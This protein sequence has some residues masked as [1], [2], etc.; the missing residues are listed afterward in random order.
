MNTCECDHDGSNLRSL[1][2]LHATHVR[3]ETAA[4]AAACAQLDA[5]VAAVRAMH[6]ADAAYGCGFY[7][8]DD[9]LAA[10]ELTARLAGGISVR[11][12]D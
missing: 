6:A 3:R 7:C 5:L 11:N 9:W 8:Q 4:L 12:N 2:G 1:C 10:Y